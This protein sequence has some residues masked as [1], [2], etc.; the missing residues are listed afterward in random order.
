MEIM[1]TAAEANLA[2]ESSRT[3]A[4]ALPK[5]KSSVTIKVGEDNSFTDVIVPMSALKL[6]LNLLGEMAQGNAV[7]IMPMHAELTSQQGADL[8]NV[9]RPFFI[10]LLDDKKIPFR[11]VGRHRRILAKDVFEF[12]QKQEQ[13]T[14]ESMKILAAEAQ[15]LK[16]GYE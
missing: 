12:R 8:L 9:S 13:L 6:L 15:K 1:P 3:L 5:R 14:E 10:K 2:K 16:L 4:K 11:K 7:T